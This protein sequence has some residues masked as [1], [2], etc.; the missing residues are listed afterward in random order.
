MFAGATISWI[1]GF[2]DNDHTFSYSGSCQ[3]ISACG[4]QLTGRRAL[5]I[6]SSDPTTGSSP[7]AVQS[8]AHPP[9][10]PPACRR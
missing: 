4:G 3:L 9:G 1:Y 5:V 7:A 6:R 10:L 2:S 8:A